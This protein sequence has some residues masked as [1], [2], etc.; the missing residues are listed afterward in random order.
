MYKLCKETI[1]DPN[2]QGSNT[3]NVSW[4]KNSHRLWQENQQCRDHVCISPRFTELLYI[5]ENYF[6]AEEVQK[7]QDPCL[8][9]ISTADV[10]KFFKRIDPCKTSGPNGIPGWAFKGV[11]RSTDRCLHRSGLSLLQ[12]VVPTFQEVHHCPC[13]QQ[14]QSPLPAWLPRSSTHLHHHE[15]LQVVNQSLHHLLIHWTHFNL[16]TDQTDQLALHVKATV[17]RI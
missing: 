12:S 6:S 11:C 13:S 15:V 5:L 10:C 9:V 2:Y 3:R 17:G 16:L 7:F 8:L 1:R 4:T 14:N